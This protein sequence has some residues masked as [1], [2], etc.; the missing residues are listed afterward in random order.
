MGS[1]HPGSVLEQGRLAAV[2]ATATGVPDEV[3]SPPDH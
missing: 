3:D 1:A 2:V